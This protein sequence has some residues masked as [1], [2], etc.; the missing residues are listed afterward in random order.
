MYAVL[1]NLSWNIFGMLGCEMGFW[2]IQ[3]M[4]SFTIVRGCVSMKSFVSQKQVGLGYI[5]VAMRNNYF[6]FRVIYKVYFNMR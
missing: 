2:I 5:G 3:T 6:V 4:W 1:I